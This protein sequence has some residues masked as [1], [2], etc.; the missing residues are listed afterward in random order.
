MPTIGPIVKIGE[1][2]YSIRY[3]D[4]N[5]DFTVHTDNRATTLTLPSL[6][7]S[8]LSVRFMYLL[9]MHYIKQRIVLTVENAWQN[10]PLGL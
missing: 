1:N 2:E 3:K 9:R 6:I 7:R 4:I 8:P 5:M 10:A